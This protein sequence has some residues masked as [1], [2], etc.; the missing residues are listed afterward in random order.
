MYSSVCSKKM[1]SYLPKRNTNGDNSEEN[2]PIDPTASNAGRLCVRVCSMLVHY[3]Y[4]VVVVVVVC[5][6]VCV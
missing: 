5:V 3:V 4:V 2:Y 6:C 1:I